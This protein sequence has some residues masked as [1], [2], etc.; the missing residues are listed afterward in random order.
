MAQFI[1]VGNA[2]VNLDQVTVLDIDTPM[3]RTVV[4]VFGQSSE[5]IWQANVQLP[6]VSAVP[7]LKTATGATLFLNAADVEGNPIG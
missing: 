3:G 7:L 4:R 1:Q 5:P 2:F 6:Q